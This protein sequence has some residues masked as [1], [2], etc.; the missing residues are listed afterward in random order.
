MKKL[1][2]LLKLWIMKTDREFFRMDEH[3]RREILNFISEST[4]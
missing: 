1:S 3:A 2:R 4:F